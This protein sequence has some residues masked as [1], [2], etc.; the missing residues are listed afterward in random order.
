ML[1]QTNIRRGDSPFDRFVGKPVWV[2]A[3]GITR[4]DGPFCYLQLT[5]KYKDLYFYQEI[6]E[7]QFRGN[8]RGNGDVS[9]LRKLSRLGHD[10]LSHMC[11]AEPVEVITDDE[12]K[13]L[14]S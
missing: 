14:L 12:M 5:K 9:D 7:Y 3:C 4:P 6:M 13:E 11:P 8:F 2:K 1:V 10:N